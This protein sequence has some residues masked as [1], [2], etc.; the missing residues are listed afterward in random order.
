MLLGL[1]RQ[2]EGDFAGAV[3][4]L[5]QMVADP[6]AKLACHSGA[7]SQFDAAMAGIALWADDGRL[8][9][10]EKAIMVGPVFLR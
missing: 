10:I 4:T 2:S 8:S 7:R 6:A 3:E 1:N 9:H 5:K